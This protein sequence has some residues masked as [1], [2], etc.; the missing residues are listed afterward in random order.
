MQTLDLVHGGGAVPTD[1]YVRTARAAQAAG[2]VSELTISLRPR[3]ALPLGPQQA[4]LSPP[5]GDVRLKQP[6][7]KA[8]K[9]KLPAASRDEL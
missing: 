7:P 5:P 4:G 8:A 3:G 6:R 1:H 2:T 9:R